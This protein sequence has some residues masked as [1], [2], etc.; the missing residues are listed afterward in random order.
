[1]YHDA[2]I[3]ERPQLLYLTPVTNPGSCNKQN[4]Q[5]MPDGYPP[6]SHHEL[7]TI[8]F[9]QQHTLIIFIYYLV[10]RQATCFGRS[11]AVQREKGDRHKHW[12][13]DNR[14]YTK[15]EEEQIT[16]SEDSN[17]TLTFKQY[18][19]E[20]HADKE[21]HILHSHATIKLTGSIKIKIL[22]NEQRNNG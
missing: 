3:R 6:A 19:Q 21:H 15:R 9:S 17:N 1:L 10:L 12:C 11:L 22:K 8:F 2:R 16:Y 5:K 4:N 13:R 18:W 14:K 20:K 7:Y